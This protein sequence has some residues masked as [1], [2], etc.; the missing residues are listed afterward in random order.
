MS[1]APRTTLSPKRIAT[2]TFTDPSAAR[3]RLEQIYERNTAFLREHFEAYLQGDPPKMR[4][5]A[6][7]PLVRITTTTHSHAVARELENSP[8]D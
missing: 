5:R 2:E 8:R 4:V 7:Y 1:A 6:T 3:D